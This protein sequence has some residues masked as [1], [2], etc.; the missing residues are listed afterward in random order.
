[1]T[2]LSCGVFYPN[3]Y[4]LLNAFEWQCRLHQPH[5]KTTYRKGQLDE[6]RGSSSIPGQKLAAYI[7]GIPTD[8]VLF[9]E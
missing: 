5:Q 8:N 1:M 6:V 4:R 9:L 2:L 3:S 7:I